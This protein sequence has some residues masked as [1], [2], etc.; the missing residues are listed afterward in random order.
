VAAGGRFQ[1]SATA[2]PVID[3]RRECSSNG[4]RRPRVCA[5]KWR[6]AEDKADSTFPSEALSPI[7]AFISEHNVLA[8]LRACRHP[9]IFEKKTTVLMAIASQPCG[10]SV[11]V[12]DGRS[13][14]PLRGSRGF[15]PRSLLR[16][17]TTERTSEKHYIMLSAF[18]NTTRYSFLAFRKILQNSPQIDPFSEKNRS[19]PTSLARWCYTGRYKR[20]NVPSRRC[21]FAM[22]P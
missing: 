19:L 5:Q 7:I 2:I 9:A 16:R 12:D 4:A 13:C 21:I 22:P 6:T 15:S 17:S 8:G 1:S 10:G 18:I 20:W 11:L 14:L 3:P